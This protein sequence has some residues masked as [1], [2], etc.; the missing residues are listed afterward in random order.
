MEPP[1]VI[2][3]HKKITDLVINKRVKEGLDLTAE[4]ASRS[5]IPDHINQQASLEGTYRNMI[6]Y[7]AG[8]IEDPER[9]KIFY[10]LLQS[11]LQLAD[12]IKQDLLSR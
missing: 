10:H 9:D 1:R 12:E 11:I 5:S 6:K 7:T 4:F 3:K 8:G 2:E